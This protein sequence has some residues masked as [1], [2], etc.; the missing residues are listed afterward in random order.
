[1]SLIVLVNLVIILSDWRCY[2][3]VKVLLICRTWKTEN[4]CSPL[5][6]IYIKLRVFFP[7]KVFAILLR[8]HIKKYSHECFCV[9]EAKNSYSCLICCKCVLHLNVQQSWYCKLRHCQLPLT[10]TFCLSLLSFIH[11]LHSTSW[12]TLK[13]NIEI[14]F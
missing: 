2:K 8:Y 7:V 4:N 14:C 13:L 5:T 1:M 6:W 9:N 3:V 11:L 12:F 10:T